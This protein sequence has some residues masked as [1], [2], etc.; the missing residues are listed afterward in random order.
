MEQMQRLAHLFAAHQAQQP[1]APPGEPAPP[2]IDVEAET[3]AGPEDR[4]GGGGDTAADA[5]CADD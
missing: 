2:V 1:A 4:E 5:G 3:I